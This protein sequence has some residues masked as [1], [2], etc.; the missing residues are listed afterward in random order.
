MGTQA[1][2]GR[3][4]SRCPRILLRAV[5]AYALVLTAVYA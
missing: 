4:L 3:F 1:S 5:I 2:A